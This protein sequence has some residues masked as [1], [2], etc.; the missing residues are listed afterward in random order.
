M[1]S[2]S[3]RPQTIINLDLPLSLSIKVNSF[4]RSPVLNEAIGGVASSQHCKGQALDLDDV[5]GYK[6]NAEMFLY[7]RENLD[8]DQLISTVSF[9]LN[10][11]LSP[12]HPPDL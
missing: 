12:P 11:S 2:C 1:V 7:I 8:F 4:F 3:L 5:Y 6:T 9:T 10:C